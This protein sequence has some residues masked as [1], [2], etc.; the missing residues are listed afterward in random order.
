SMIPWDYNLAFGTFQG[1]NASSSVNQSIDEVL[2]DRPMQAWIFS[3]EEYSAQY[4]A[5]YAEML[6][7]VN[8]QAIIEH[9]YGLIAPY[10]QEDPTAFCS[11]EEFEK[12]VQVLKEFC[13]LRSES[14]ALQLNGSEATVDTGDLNISDMG[15]MGG[16]FGGN[17]E[18]G[19]FE[20]NMQGPNVGQDGMT[21]PNNQGGNMTPSDMTQDGNMVPPDMAQGGDMSGANF[22]SGMPPRPT[23]NEGDTNR[24]PQGNRFEDTD[25]PSASPTSS[26]GVAALIVSFAVLAAGL[27]FVLLFKRRKDQI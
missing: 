2:S 9:A 16:G 3:S 13:L 1:A 12:G 4:Y 6:E 8:P 24:A 19:G 22:P 23:V 10:V 11:A 15:S 17:R 7:S 14:V 27:V 20:G 5:L 25:A 18:N 21:F 26:N